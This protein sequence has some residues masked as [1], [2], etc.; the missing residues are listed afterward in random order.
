MIID[1]IDFQHWQRPLFDFSPIMPDFGE[2]FVAFTMIYVS[3]HKDV[4]SLESFLTCP[5]QQRKDEVGWLVADGLHRYMIY[6]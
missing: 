1:Q 2:A 3:Y 5:V 4:Q 6:L